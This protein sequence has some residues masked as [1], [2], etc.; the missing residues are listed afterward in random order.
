[1][2][3]S[4]LQLLSS[5]QVFQTQLYCL[6]AEHRWL[7]FRLAPWHGSISVCFDLP[8][9]W[10]INPGSD[11]SKAWEEEG[12]VGIL[13]W[14]TKLYNL[15]LEWLC[16][17]H[18]LFSKGNIF[19]RMWPDTAWVVSMMYDTYYHILMYLTLHLCS[20]FIGLWLSGQQG[21]VSCF[22]IDNFFS[23]CFSLLTC[24]DRG[25]WF[26]LFAQSSVCLLTDSSSSW[27]FVLL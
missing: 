6:F 18:S 2:S 21:C 20:H 11:H 8:R 19:K 17:I 9:V 3:V 16:K 10:L 14:A 24:Q 27:P 23:F 22:L 26:E 5:T 25:G 12:R 15:L 4:S 7:C 1:M 13:S